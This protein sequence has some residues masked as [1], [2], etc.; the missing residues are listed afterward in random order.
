MRQRG[1]RISLCLIARDEERFLPACLASARGAVDEAVVVDTGSRDAT[2]ALAR[3]AGARVVEFAWRDDFA[4]ARNASLAA[5]T[6]DWVLVLDADERLAPGAAAT[7]RAA[8]RRPQAPAGLLRLH[9]ASR[10]DATAAQVLSGEARLGEPTEVQRLF[11]RDPDLAFEGVVH[12][13]V[14][15][16]LARRGRVAM[17]LPADVVHLGAVPA[18]REERGKAAR[19]L[20][21]LRRRWE[22]DPTDLAAAGYLAQDLYAQGEL[23]EARRVVEQA[24]PH[25]ERA[26]LYLT[27]RLSVARALL[28]RAARDPAAM[29][30]TVADEERRK[31]RHAELSF[32]R[33]C[34]L[35]ELA[36]A[37][38]PGSGAR[39]A[40][41]CGAEAAYREATSDRVDRHYDS[42]YGARSWLGQSRLGTVL[43][44]LGRAR[45]AA[46]AFGA[47]LQASPG[48]PA[49]TVGL[50]EAELAAGDPAGA[51]RRCLPLVE[52]VA[53]AWLVAAWAA[54]ALGRGEESRLF[55]ARARAER[56][57]LC[58]WHR[59]E[60]LAAA[61]P[62]DR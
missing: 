31:G 30:E 54:A 16:W 48:D 8:V 62:A 37:A 56:D 38:P 59:A 49:A 27:L 15:S 6:G 4:A 29:L 41:L 25:R 36:A 19:N 33:G 46:V 53:D 58:G 18:L 20:R 42:I 45:E 11:R 60:A 13:H 39:R 22:G 9:D 57:R 21:L 23:D 50:A 2:R 14:S 43:L 47:A 7:I 34:A 10:L 35:E 51:L 52:R 12:E 17:R 28:A 32:L 40:R 61:G 3:R 44:A 24:W 5:A 1:C 26:T 55:L